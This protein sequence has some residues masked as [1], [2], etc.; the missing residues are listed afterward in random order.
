MVE[1]LLQVKDL[2]LAAAIPKCQ[3]QE[4]AKRQRA[5]MARCAP[6]SSSAIQKVHHGKDL[7]TTLQACPGCGAK[8]HQGGRRQCP[9]FNQTC[10]LCQ[11]IGHFAKVCRGRQARQH[12]LISTAQ[13]QA[14]TKAVFTKA[15]KERE[16]PRIH[17]SNVREATDIDP[18]PTITV[19]IS[20]LNGS[21]DMEILLDSG[22]DI[23]A[24][25]KEALR[26]LGEHVNN[27]L[28]SNI[29]P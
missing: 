6:K 22:A 16:S 27:L 26:C 20:S 7:P 29:I 18:A 28:P 1:D 23:S 2:T 19:H 12:T 11:K 5:E 21:A 15:S 4:A 13:P 25:G 17:M 14:S 3:G 9:A 8:L 10:H 24:A